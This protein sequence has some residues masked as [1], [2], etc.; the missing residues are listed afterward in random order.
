MVMIKT[1]FIFVSNLF[2]IYQYVPHLLVLDLPWSDFF[3]GS[4]SL[5]LMCP[6]VVLNTE[7]LGSNT[8]DKSVDC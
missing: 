2:F 4:E 8:L 6:K 7:V 5:L 3:T 1:P